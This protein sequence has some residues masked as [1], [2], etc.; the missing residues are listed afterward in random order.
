MHDAVV[1]AEAETESIVEAAQTNSNSAPEETQASPAAA[2][3][4]RTSRASN[5]PREV[6]RRERE[7]ALRA[8]GVKIG[9]AKKNQDTTE[10][11]SSSSS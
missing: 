7:D 5:D 2:K 9:G 10:G 4:T 3:I 11:S 6:K 1:E 8:Q